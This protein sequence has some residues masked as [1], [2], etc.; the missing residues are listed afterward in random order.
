MAN[1]IKLT[2]DGMEV[3]VEKGKTILDAAQAAGVRIPTLCHDRRLVPFGACRVC[4]VQQKGKADLLPACF[5]PAR[6]GMEIITNS[7]EVIA[8]RKL[9][10]QLILLNHPM[11]CPRCEKEGECVLQNLVYEYGV[12]ETRYPWEREPFPVD[13]IS[14]LLQRDPNKCILCGRC[15][16]I[17]DEVQGIRELSFTGRGNKTSIDTD[18]HRPI[19]C[20]FCGQCLDTCPVGAITSD[21]FDYR[22]KGWELKETTTPCPFCGCGCAITFGSK[23]GEV[24]RVFS[25][26]GKGAPHDGPN[27]GNLCVKGRFGWDF[28]DHPDRLKKPLLRKDG[29]LEEVSWDEALRFVAK[30]L[31]EVKDQHG[32]EAI[33]AI[34]S[35]RLTNEEYFLFRKLFQEAL[36]TDQID[37]DGSEMVHGLT[38]GLAKTLGIAASTNSIREIRKADCLLIIGVD[39]AQTHPIIRNEVHLAI[40]QNR[41][42]LIVLGCQDIGLTLATQLSP[43]IHPSILLQGKPGFEVPVLNA[44]ARTVLKQG[45]EDGQFIEENTEGIADL[46]KKIFPEERD[47][48]QGFSE[49]LKQEIGRAAKAF[50]QAKKAMILIGVGFCFPEEGREIAMASSNLALTTGHIGKASCG[51]LMLLE[52]CNSQGAIDLGIFPKKSGRGSKEFLQKAKEQKLKALYLVGHDPLMADTDHTAEGMKKLRLLVVQDLFMTE[53][54]KMA[55]V[56]LP[57]CAF[58]EKS[59]TYTSLERRVQKI[60]PFR[61]PLGESKSDFDIFVQ[62]LRLLESPIPGETQEAVFEEIARF[63]PFYK[64]I[65]DG[66]QWPKDSP[67]LYA[68]GFPKGKAQLIPVTGTAVTKK[69]DGHPFQLM[70]RASLFQ[71]GVLSSKSE[72]LEMV[73]EEPSLELNHEDAEKHNVED[74]ETVRLSTPGG[75]TARMKVEYSSK[76]QPGVVTV[77]YPSSLFDEGNIV[78]VKIEKAAKT[79]DPIVR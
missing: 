78:S 26:T 9:Q 40:R 36:G 69:A 37:H 45:L 23:D 59:G 35:S 25:D 14:S 47:G 42:Q 51:I 20:E 73:S 13:E 11:I 30:E 16:R 33:A 52:K 71:S 54:A 72:A 29:V 57:A 22:T 70:R 56:V 8:S 19:N 53:T 34:A 48:V 2:I 49:E 18:F 6:A 41:A 15:V 38:E 10:L 4:V 68:T 21:R 55:H 12:E 43:L 79:K 75:R 63:N 62:L 77:P 76:L 66:E 31:E 50:A 65:K 27:D 44:M 1:Q 39:P 5:T 46:R 74:G 64:G 3:E 24:K 7:P 58:V 32:P 60:Q 61:S 28:I 17:C 67:Y